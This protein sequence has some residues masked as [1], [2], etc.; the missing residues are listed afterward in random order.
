[1]QREYGFGG[2]LASHLPHYAKRQA[3]SKLFCAER[4]IETFS[5]MN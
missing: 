4:L 3:D 5:L 1:M 2:L